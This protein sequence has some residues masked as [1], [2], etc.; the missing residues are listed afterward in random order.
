[1][2]LTTQYRLIVRQV[3][4][5][6]VVRMLRVPGVADLLVRGAAAAEETDMRVLLADL[7]TGASQLWTAWASDSRS[8][9][10]VCL[11][12]ISDSDGRFVCVSMLAGKD[13][14]RWARVLEAAIAEFARTENCQSVRFA[15]KRGWLRILPTYKF[16]GIERGHSVFER[17]L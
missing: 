2:Q 4:L 14:R 17:M 3:A 12:H 10:A 8:P 16:I 11:T 13:V 1:M 15:G 5:A 6:N 9:M 7:I